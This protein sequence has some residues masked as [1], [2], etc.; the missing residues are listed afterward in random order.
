LS[1]AFDAE[2]RFSDTALLDVVKGA[3]LLAAENV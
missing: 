2:V 1:S 3:Q